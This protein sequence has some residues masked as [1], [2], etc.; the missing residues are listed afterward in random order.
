MSE[1]PY[2]AHVC[3]HTHWDREWY[4]PFQTYR[5]RLVRLMDHLLDTLEQDS[6][7]R[8]FNLDGQTIP[9]TDYLEIRPENET[10][11]RN[12]ISDGRIIIAFRDWGVNGPTMGHFVAWVGTY[13][14][15]KNGKPGQYRVKLLHSYAG[16]DCGY[17]GVMQVK[18][19]SIVALTY[20]KYK[21]GSA[22]HSVVATRFKLSE[23]DK[24]LADQKK[25][26]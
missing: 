9:L 1:K 18:D 20:I 13:D 25:K 22:K 26:K 3:P 19:G 15:I 14:D 4:S 23:L 5:M 24:K 17:P 7:F 2:I 6:D 10:R 16:R 21:P 11:L 12:L 8:L